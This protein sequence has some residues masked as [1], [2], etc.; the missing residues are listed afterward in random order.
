MPLR[1]T[2]STA[3]APL[4]T[5]ADLRRVEKYRI[6]TSSPL[7]QHNTHSLFPSLT[8]A[9]CAHNTQRNLHRT[10]HT[11]QF[12]NEARKISIQTLIATRNSCANTVATGY[13]RS[14]HANDPPE[15]R[16]TSPTATTIREYFQLH[17]F[18]V[19][20]EINAWLNMREAGL[21]VESFVAKPI[22]SRVELPRSPLD[23]V[24]CV[25]RW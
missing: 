3:R 15:R 4:H 21:C 19:K 1:E 2:V 14:A 13:Q 11:H 9:H 8:Q 7:E 20:K 12:C 23:G 10:L 25:Q 5:S 22:C 16:K 24:S 18:L 17:I 6:Q